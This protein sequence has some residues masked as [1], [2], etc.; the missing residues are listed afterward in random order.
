MMI[1]LKLSVKLKILDLSTSTSR[2][3]LKVH[4]SLNSAKILELKDQTELTQSQV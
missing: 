4:K 1:Y 3:F 2:R